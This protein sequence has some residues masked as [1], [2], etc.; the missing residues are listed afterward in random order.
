MIRPITSNDK[1][2]KQLDP[3]NE[4]KD[5]IVGSSANDKGNMEEVK[6]EYSIHQKFNKPKRSIVRRA[7]TKNNFDPEDLPIHQVFFPYTVNISYY[8]STRQTNLRHF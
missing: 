8:A 2:S 5:V 6:V 7:S 3:L 4:D 1:D